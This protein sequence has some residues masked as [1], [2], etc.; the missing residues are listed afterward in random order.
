MN[1]CLDTNIFITAW[2]ED[3]P[4]GVF[5]SLWEQLANSKESFTVIKPIFDEIEPYT[6]N[7]KQLADRDKIEKYPLRMWIEENI[8]PEEDIQDD[9]RDMALE[10]EKKYKTETTGKGA[11]KTDILLI[12]YAKAYKKTVVTLEAE[13]KQRPQKTHNY[14]IPLICEIE[15][16]DWINLVEFLKKLGIRI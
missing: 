16:I 13:Q 11:G 14:K 6:G 5:P 12:A 15:E 2:Y 10:L 7:N 4:P 9:I 3:Y 8:L 1:Y